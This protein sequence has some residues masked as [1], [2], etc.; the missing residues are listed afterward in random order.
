MSDQWKNG[1]AE[2]LLPKGLVKRFCFGLVLLVIMVGVV[3]LLDKLDASHFD[4]EIN[5]AQQY[6]D[7]KD[8][9]AAFDLLSETYRNNR[10]K[11]D[12]IL[13]PLTAKGDEL[14]KLA[15]SG[16]FAGYGLPFKGRYDIKEPGYLYFYLPQEGD[17][18]YEENVY[19]FAYSKTELGSWE[20]IKA[21]FQ[22]P[23]AR[24]EYFE[25]DYENGL[26]F[27]QEPRLQFRTR[28]NKQSV[29]YMKE[30]FWC[31]YASGKLDLKDDILLSPLDLPMA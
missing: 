24:M 2:F 17:E 1:V 5:S 29:L 13:A 18:L 26:G 23:E 25:L 9:K 6:I 22:T 30:T 11:R 10:T 20:E 3:N 7:Q 14:L 19:Y 21:L 31:D 15:T 4:A 16:V 12:T 27:N 8:Y 28:E